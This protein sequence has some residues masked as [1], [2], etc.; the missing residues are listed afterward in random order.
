MDREF[1]SPHVVF[2]NPSGHQ[3]DL[4]H[5]YCYQSGANWRIITLWRGNNLL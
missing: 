3:V 5:Y 1:C 2:A 4:R